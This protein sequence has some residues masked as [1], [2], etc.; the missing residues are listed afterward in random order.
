[1]EFIK[2]FVDVFL[3]L[4]VYLSEIIHDYGVWTYAP[5]VAGVGR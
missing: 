1:M 2:G 3:H 5:F 4:D